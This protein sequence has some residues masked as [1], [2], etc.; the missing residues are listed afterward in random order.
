LI[1][2]HSD[3]I[4]T[5]FGLF[6]VLVASS[7]FALLVGICFHEACH[8]FTANALGDS[9]P[10]RQGRVTLNPVA[11]LDPFGTVLM[12]L[13]GFGWGKPVQFNPY[14][15]NVSPKTASFLVALAGPL[16]NFVAAGLIA[17]PIQLGW[18]PYINPISSFTQ[19]LQFRVQSTEDYIGLFL[20]GAVYLNCILGV[21]NLI[22][23]PPLDGYKVALFLL[24]DDIAREFAKLDQY[25]FA[26]L[27][28]I[29]FGIPFLTGYSPLADIMGPSVRWL[30]HLFTG[31]G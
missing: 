2:I 7:L 1:L 15:L 19:F 26:I 12:L 24:P 8:A 21:F 20:T 28:V 16:S 14:G 11:H 27:L 29:L 4:D 17:I 30:V 5:D 13:V 22:P 23:I 10:A 25:G 31:V 6:L 3:L 9:L 18:V